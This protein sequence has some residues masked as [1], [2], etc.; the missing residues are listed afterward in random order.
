LVDNCWTI[1]VTA[2]S[3]VVLALADPLPLRPRAATYQWRKPAIAAAG[4]AA[5]A[6]YVVSTAL[7]GM[8][9][10]YNDVGH[11][12]FNRDDF[13]EAER[14]HFKA[15]E[16]FPNHPIFLDN[17]GMVYL[18]QF[19]ETKKSELLTS[20][21]VYFVRA[22]EGNP[23]A[24]DPHIHMEALLVRSLTGELQRDLE[25]NREIVRNNLQLLAI[26]PFIPF[27]RKNL[28]SAYYNLGQYEHAMQE[29]QKAIEYE[30]NYVPGY[31]QLADWYQ[32]HGDVEASRL[33]TAVALNI[34]HKYKNFRPT[35]AYEGILLGRPQQSMPGRG[36]P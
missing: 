15:I 6:M 32:E 31:L 28:A 21:K 10:Y 27:V 35:E 18:Q 36:G 23:N 22:I 34:V 7:P 8:G 30:P 20:A 16:L 26:D 3:L 11:K 12:A 17:L 19:T 9:L 5:A 2:S 14:Y 13:A 24:I 29:V 25:V 4:L 1:P 33:H